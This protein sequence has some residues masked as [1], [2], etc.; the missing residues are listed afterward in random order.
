MLERER[1][2][3]VLISHCSYEVATCNLETTTLTVHVIKSVSVKESVESILQ[4]SGSP[5]IPE[6]S[7]R[8]CRKYTR[9]PTVTTTG[10]EW[11]S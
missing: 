7:N 11:F 6:H 5:D 2:Y 3:I 10:T 9:T 4:Q 8:L 1:R